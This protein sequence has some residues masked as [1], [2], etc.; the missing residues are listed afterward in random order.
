L[1]A[2]NKQEKERAIT[3]ITNGTRLSAKSKAFPLLLPL[4]FVPASIPLGRPKEIQKPAAGKIDQ[5]GKTGGQTQGL[6]LALPF[7]LLSAQR[8]RH[9]IALRRLKNAKNHEQLLRVKTKII[10]AKMARV[11]PS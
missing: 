4:A 10:C 3:I 11:L 8:E 2:E 1:A 7:P 9:G 6:P 5:C